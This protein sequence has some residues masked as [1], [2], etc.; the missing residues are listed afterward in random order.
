M[1]FENFLTGVSSIFIFS[2]DIFGENDNQMPS[3]FHIA[4]G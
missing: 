2:S 3:N 1:W 4:F